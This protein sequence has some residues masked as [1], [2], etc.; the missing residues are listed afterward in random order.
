LESLRYKYSLIK[1][2]NKA[3]IALILLYLLIAYLYGYKYSLT[4]IDILRMV[5]VIVVSFI[6]PGFV[7]S[8]V[9]CKF[10]NSPIVERLLFYLLIGMPVSLLV[11]YMS[12]YYESGIIFLIFIIV[13]TIIS[14]ISFIRCIK[15]YPN[16]RKPI[17]ENSN[18]ILV[19]LAVV[20]IFNINRPEIDVRPIVLN[21]EKVYDS[22]LYHD[23]LFDL[24]QAQLLIKD[25]DMEYS[26]M[27][28]GV[29]S[30][31]GYYMH[32][33]IA[34]TLVPFIA[35]YSNVDPVIVWALVVPVLLQTLLAFC[36]YLILRQVIND[37]YLA[38]L[39]FIIMVSALPLEFFLFIRENIA[40]A[41]PIYDRMSE[42]NAVSFNYVRYFMPSIYGFCIFY[43]LLRYNKEKNLRILCLIGLILD[44]LFF[45]RESIFLGAF[46]AISIAFLY[47]FIV[48][49][50][51]KKLFYGISSIS[52]LFLPVMFH[53]FI[54]KEVFYNLD[55][56]PFDPYKL[57]FKIGILTDYYHENIKLL[58][59]NITI[60]FLEIMDNFSNY[61]PCCQKYLRDIYTLIIYDIGRGYGVLIIF[62]VIGALFIHKK[63]IA[64]TFFIMFWLLLTVFENSVYTILSS[65]FL[66]YPLIVAMNKRNICI[67]QYMAVLIFLIIVSMTYLMVKKKF[68]LNFRMSFKEFI[69]ALG[70]LSITILPIT[71]INNDNGV[72]RY[73]KEWKFIINNNLLD[74]YVFLLRN[75]DKPII[76]M[77]NV[78][79]YQDFHMGYHNP[80]TAFTGHYSLLSSPGLMMQYGLF[81]QEI[82][83]RMRDIRLFYCT[84]SVSEYERILK[85]YKISYVIDNGSLKIKNHLK[86]IK[87]ASPY[88]LYKV[89]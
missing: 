17:I 1:L 23:N 80:M 38:Y 76:V 33:P 10:D 39:G 66:N 37:R 85:R 65:N 19:S 88:S 78:Y 40:N 13:S 4:S 34:H 75:V 36:A 22:Y 25:N 47:H 87:Q 45:I 71:Y 77:E 52:V 3:N 86:L 81:E 84:D 18:L 9:L 58:G 73:F 89:V 44:A 7:I 60:K 74:I 31:W 46:I 53:Y 28:G 41:G 50:D 2:P 27:L 29:R 82:A 24:A 69:V 48:E 35:K 56:K 5:L 67:M 12:N 14:L 42:N 43:L 83:D 11:F 63:N 68:G 30:K 61:L 15:I 62:L 6:I 79:S 72:D 57:G 21:G 64:Y 32:S 54:N 16:Q 51:R 26:Y 55:N 20:L 59:S 70:L 8:I 49:Q